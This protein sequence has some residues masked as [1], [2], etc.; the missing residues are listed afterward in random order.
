M[1]TVSEV[2][3]PLAGICVPVPVAGEG[4]C[5]VCHTHTREG[6]TTC[7]SCY[8]TTSQVSKP[9]RL[10]VPISLYEIPSQLHHILRYYKSDSYNA[11][12]RHDFAVKTV[13][14]LCHFLGLHRACIK[15]AAGVDWD[16]VTNVPSSSGRAGEHP[17]V[18]A[19]RMVP[20]VF[21]SYEP[22]LRRGPGAID[23]LVASDDGYLATGSVRG[24]RVLLIDDTFTSGAR[25]QSAASALALAG[26][27]V[28]AIVPIGRVVDPHWDHMPE[29]WDVQKRKRFTFRDCCLDPF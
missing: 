23:H 5:A 28:V 13:V 6:Y 21:E 14:L 10:V 4:V 11:A 7:W 9:C 25:A 24:R 3:G 20:S 1:A 12:R 17:L 26:A 18:A 16:V 2:A 27:R 15:V 8:K 22:L 29:W 19:L